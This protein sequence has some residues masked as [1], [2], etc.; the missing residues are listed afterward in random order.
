LPTLAENLALDEALLEEAELAGHS[1]G[2]LRFWESPRHA[3]VLG[4]SSVSADEV[5]LAFCEQQGMAVMRRCSG[6]ASV[7]VGPGCLMYSVILPI[8]ARPE[9][10]RIDNAH[11]FVL[12]TLLRGIHTLVPNA[13]CAGTSDLA[14]DAKKFSGNSL[15][16]KRT[17]LLYHGTLLY[18]FPLELI[19]Q[20]LRTAP[21]QPEYRSGRDHLDFVHNL[22][23]AKTPLQNAIANAWGA[24]SFRAD[25]PRHSTSLLVTNRYH[26]REWNL[27]R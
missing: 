9:L 6:G 14:C 15:R 10:A 11:C 22:P 18:D 13:T 23:I 7:V 5:D 8:E 1:A 24:H 20:C 16:V 27:A 4:R 2:T 3:V 25:W 17:H 26:K 19:Q 21:R 12:Q